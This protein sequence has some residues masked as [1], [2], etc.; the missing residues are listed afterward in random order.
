MH[1]QLFQIIPSLG[2]LTLA[3]GEAPANHESPATDE[4]S[5]INGTAVASDSQGLVALQMGG[6]LCSGTLLTTKWILTAKHCTSGVA[7]D[8]VTATLG[9]TNETSTSVAILEHPTLDV[10]LVQLGVPFSSDSYTNN[11]WA[12]STAA[13]QNRTLTCYGYGR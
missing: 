8:G 3:C 7:A 4:S 11:L 12:S 13:L 5:I 9:T 10:S 6:G 2:L 1:K